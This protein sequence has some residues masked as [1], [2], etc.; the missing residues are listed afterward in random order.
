M[1]L[2]VHQR[3][4]AAKAA[5]RAGSL[6]RSEFE[7]WFSN[8]ESM[9]DEIN[10]KLV[11]HKHADAIPAD[12]VVSHRH[13]SEE[14]RSARNERREQSGGSQ[15][16]SSVNAARLRE[17]SR[18]VKR[19]Q[20]TRTAPAAGPGTRA[21]SPPSRLP[22]PSRASKIPVRTG[23]PGR[24]SPPRR[25][26]PPRGARSEIG[27]DAA[28]RRS[29]AASASG[30]GGAAGEGASAESAP[31]A[32]PLLVHS[33]QQQA[34]EVECLLRVPIA[35]AASLARARERVESSR[36]F[37]GRITQ[38][39]SEH[40]LLKGAIFQALIAGLRLSGVE[41]AQTE[42]SAREGAEADSVRGALGLGQTEWSALQARSLTHVH[43]VLAV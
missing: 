26:S 6:D 39:A 4:Q 40:N 21:A 32:A 2:D 9:Y 30:A 25:G 18:D 37:Y 3:E 12:I 43:L 27:C 34:V 1:P 31:S 19:A 24:R 35:D 16:V 13:A 7:A 14:L 20:P 5:S 38:L 22:Q 10:S 41:H 11:L 42:L 36:R 8:L 23:S 17:R 28:Q 15:L 33:L 29:A